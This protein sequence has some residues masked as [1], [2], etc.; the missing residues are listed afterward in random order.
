MVFEPAD[1]CWHT[2]Y[3]LQRLE[4]TILNVISI[5]NIRISEPLLP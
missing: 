1:G 4:F 3:V 2:L 5:L